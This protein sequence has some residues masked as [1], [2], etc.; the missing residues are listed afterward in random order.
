MSQEPIS[1]IL[2]EPVIDSMGALVRVLEKSKQFEMLNVPTTE[3]ALQVAQQF[4]PCVILV[5]LRGSL[6]GASQVEL[7]KKLEKPIRA[8]QLKALVVSSVKNHPLAKNIAAIG[9]TDYAEEPITTKSLLFK[10]NFIVKAI[11]A[12][13]KRTD[14]SKSIEQI[15]F[16]ANESKKSD[17][18]V[19]I[20]AEVPAKYKPALQ[21]G[22]DTFVF[23][24]T[25]PRKIGQKFILEAE[26][27]LPDT[28]DWEAVPGKKGEEQKWKWVP[29]INPDGEALEGNK[30]GGWIHDGEK[31]AFDVGKGKWHLK[32]QKPRLEFFKD[33]RA[34]GSKVETDEDGNVVIAEDSQ[35]AK[36]NLMINKTL[37][38]QARE[39]F[40]KKVVAFQEKE[41]QEED[42][43]KIAAK[44]TAA[45]AGAESENSIGEDIQPDIFSNKVGAR[46]E[47]ANQKIGKNKSAIEG[48]AGWDASAHRRELA[49]KKRQKRLALEEK[50]AE[51]ER[52]DRRK[53]KKDLGSGAEELELQIREKSL[54]GLEKDDLEG[55][56]NIRD[57]MRPEIEL[58]L[59]KEEFPEGLS[60]DQLASDQNSF[61][62]REG[63]VVKN[64]LG[65]EEK[66]KEWN[67][68]ES[69]LSED[70]EKQRPELDSEEEEVRR[71]RDAKALER[72]TDRAQKRIAELRKQV[73]E[74]SSRPLNDEMTE[75]EE[76]ALRHELGVTDR[77]KF[78]RRELKQKARLERA[79]AS[80]KEIHDISESLEGRGVPLEALF[81]PEEESDWSQQDSDDLKKKRNFRAIDSID[82][83]AEDL[84]GL[85]KK[86]KNNKSGNEKSAVDEEIFFLLQSETQPADGSWECEDGVWIYLPNF[87][88]ESGIEQL[89]DLLPA[90][91]FTGEDEPEL[92][93]EEKKWK[94]LGSAPTKVDSANDLP[95]AIKDLLANLRN[96]ASMAL[97]KSGQAKHIEGISER[98]R[99]KRFDDQAD[100]TGPLPKAEGAAERGSLREQEGNQSSGRRERHPKGEKEEASF[101]SKER[102]NSID[103]GEDI[104]GKEN[105]EVRKKRPLNSKKAG[106]EID[107]L[108]IEDL[109]ESSR[110]KLNGG[111]KKGFGKVLVEEANGED[112]DLGKVILEEEQAPELGDVSQENANVTNGFGK[113]KSEEVDAEEVGEAFWEKNK[114]NE[115]KKTRTDSV[116]ENE[117][118]QSDLVS[119]QEEDASAKAQKNDGKESRLDGGLSESNSET[120]ADEVAEETR[121]GL[122]GDEGIDDDAEINGEK[123][124]FSLLARELLVLVVISD[125]KRKKVKF[126]ERIPLFEKTVA[127][128]FPDFRCR[129]SRKKI[130]GGSAGA[131]DLG[132][133]NEISIIIR[134]P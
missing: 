42:A 28:G 39:E 117:K 12:Q 3:E 45:D 109:E 64:L 24:G 8:G 105:R 133:C 14:S 48:E 55:D 43:K 71:T 102:V 62:K 91:I 63:K 35:I 89:D 21:F 20:S 129:F 60:K 130:G 26:G 120:R 53:G 76:R 80:K 123:P 75:E 124:E 25:P 30:D 116:D 54:E 38:A 50:E 58:N 27:P 2:L 132:I 72:A 128:A 125:S 87:V 108:G 98:V 56:Q 16:K 36:E 84:F 22:E 51:L 85:G 78:T 110:R 57:K 31:P 33:G 15:V 11:V 79:K 100:N 122:F 134:S 101:D 113:A 7:L 106:Q 61:Q 65:Q 88:F 10:I 97:G 18:S 29:K 131:A 17:E 13:R 4:L 19:T 70:D 77:P 40:V 47:E 96:Q 93:V 83:E 1:I 104:E 94:F 49:E 119:D 95:R 46:K 74:E 82:K 90:W 34:V 69:E 126:D 103:Q 114:E 67:E 115:A 32:S 121:V 92:L 6:D 81:P 111:D 5:S 9:V 112:K 66:P 99:R 37:A 23:K 41:K 107:E 44:K 86:N 68:V 73:L 118:F 59:G 52:A 127:V